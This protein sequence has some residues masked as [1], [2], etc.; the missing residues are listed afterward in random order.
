MPTTHH[1]RHLMAWT[2]ENTAQSEMNTQLEVKLNIAAMMDTD[3]MD[4]R[5]HNVNT[6]TENLVGRTEHLS[7]NVSCLTIAE[8]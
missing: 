7:V 2:M 6:T 5:G 1:V 3:Y 8:R 4:Q